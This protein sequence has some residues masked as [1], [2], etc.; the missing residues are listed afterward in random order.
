MKAW[1][2]VGWFV[3]YLGNFRAAW[4]NHLPPVLSFATSVVAAGGGTVLP[5]LSARGR[6]SFPTRNL[7]RFLVGCVVAAPALRTFLVL[8]VPHSAIAGYCLDALPDG[9]A[10][11]G[12]T[13]GRRFRSG[14]MPR[15]A[16][17]RL[18]FLIGGAA[19]AAIFYA[20]C[21]GNRKGPLRSVDA[22]H[23]LLGCRLYLC[24]A[25]LLG[26]R[27]PGQR[28]NRM[29][30]WRPLVYTG[31][32][33]YGLYLSARTGILGGAKTSRQCRDPFRAFRPH[34]AG[35]QFC[36]RRSIMAIFRV[37]LPGVEGSLPD[38][39]IEECPSITIASKPLRRMSSG[40]ASNEGA[41]R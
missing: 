24:F 9:R 17:S 26:A 2:G 20:A 39:R 4:A 37:A 29:L 7:P 11:D 5:V 35:G 16:S 8:F 15:A 13:A 31:Q 27:L 41:W 33:A 12:R 21:R 14:A 23:G 32:I 28:L 25:A 19:S 3:V 22:L 34:H 18:A 36:R 10:G 40:W 6:A 38:A 30:R 1:G